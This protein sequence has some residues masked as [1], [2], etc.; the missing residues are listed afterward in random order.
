MTFRRSLRPALAVLS[1]ILVASCSAVEEEAFSFEALAH[2]VA[3]IPVG[4]AADTSRAYPSLP[5]SRELGLRPAMHLDPERPGSLVVEV[6]DPHALWDARDGLRRSV[7][8][9]PETLL[10]QGDEAIRR[11]QD[12]LR[13]AAATVP[14]PAPAPV[15]VPLPAPAPAQVPSRAS[16]ATIQ[17]GAFSSDAAARA[18]WNRVSTGPAAEALAGLEPDFVSVRINGKSMVR[19]RISAPSARAYVICRAADIIDPWCVKAT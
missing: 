8:S 3:S 11:R 16:P 5:S 15:S 4:G 6:L 13:P 14:A 12:G 10:P 7:T 9:M 17:L 2:E 1:G 19:L 18:A